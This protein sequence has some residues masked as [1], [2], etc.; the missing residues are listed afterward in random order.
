MEIVKI[1]K[2]RM[3]QILPQN[4]KDSDLSVN[5]MKMLATIINYHLVDDKVRSAGFLA[6]NNENLRQS[7]GIGKE[8]LKNAWKELEECKL[9]TRKAGKKWKAGE[10]SEASE[11]RLNLENIKKFT[12]KPTADELLETLFSAPLESP[13]TKE[14][15]TI[16]YY[17]DTT[18]TSNINSESVIKTDSESYSTILDSTKLNCTILDSTRLDSTDTRSTEKSKVL[19]EIDNLPF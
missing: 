2:E 5:A 9:I 18:T 10:K 6:I 11:Y 4:V 19:D 8:Y 1:T 12:K 3:E 14:S 7:T 15:P 16:L 17:T 13:S